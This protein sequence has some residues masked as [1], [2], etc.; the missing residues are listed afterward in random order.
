MHRVEENRDIREIMERLHDHRPNLDALTY[1]AARFK[2]LGMNEEARGSALDLVWQV[3]A[4]ARSASIAVGAM[5]LD[6]GVFL[7]RRLLDLVSGVVS[8]PAPEPPTLNANAGK[9]RESARA[10]SAA[11]RASGLLT[12][13]RRR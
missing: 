10:A 9:I 4:A 5:A 11:A 3:V 2:T 8:T 1:E 12:P 13:R 6:T 7:G